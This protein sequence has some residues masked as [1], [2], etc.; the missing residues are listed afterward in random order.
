MAGLQKYHAF[1]G[2]TDGPFPNGSIAHY[3]KTMWGGHLAF[4]RACP[5]AGDIAA[6]PPRTAYVQGG[7]DTFFTIP[8]AVRIAGKNVRGFLTCDENGWLFTP[9]RKES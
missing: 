2:S 4:V 6:F 9:N 7:A 1:G 5:M 8:A 3:G